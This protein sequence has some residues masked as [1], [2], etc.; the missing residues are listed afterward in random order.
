[1]NLELIHLD[2]T[3]WRPN[4]TATSADE[5]DQV[6]LELL[7]REN[8]VMDGNYPDSLNLR[9]SYADTVVFLDY[10]RWLCLWRCTKRFLRHRGSNRPELAPGCYEKIDWDFLQWIWNYPRDVKPRVWATLDRYAGEK[11][12]IKLRGDRQVERFLAE[13]TGSGTR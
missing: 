3:Y 12:I 6:L 10:P 1:M 8:W 4:W 5:W 13:L 2:S 11:R 7:E 9:L